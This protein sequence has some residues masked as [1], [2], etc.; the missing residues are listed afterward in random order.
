M[1][2]E[3]PARIYEWKAAPETRQKAAD[4]QLRNREQFVKAFAQGLACLGYERA[5]NGNGAFLLGR[6]DEN[7]SYSST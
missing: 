3:V 7:F 4:L 1:R 5:E 2:I 6:W